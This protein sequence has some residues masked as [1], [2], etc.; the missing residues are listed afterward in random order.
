MVLSP[1][2]LDDRV[3]QVESAST[4]L[5]CAAI[6]IRVGFELPL[7]CGK[8][9]PVLRHSELDRYLIE[10]DMAN[11]SPP[12]TCNSYVQKVFKVYWLYKKSNFKNALKIFHM[13]RV[14]RL[15][16]MRDFKFRNVSY[17]SFLLLPV[18]FLKSIY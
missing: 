12:S 15:K 6:K 7:S 8:Q 3:Q 13:V 9:F 11:L 16:R 4:L 1:F 18:E 10:Y 17:T 5:S 2:G 14:N